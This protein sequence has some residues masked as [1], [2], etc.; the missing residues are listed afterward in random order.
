M[1]NVIALQYTIPRLKKDRGRIHP[2]TGDSVPVINVGGLLK[3][4]VLQRIL[5]MESVIVFPSEQY[6]GGALVHIPASV[7]RIERPHPHQAGNLH[8]L[9]FGVGETVLEQI[10]ELLHCWGE[11]AN[12]YLWRGGQWY[13]F[14][15]KRNRDFHPCY[16]ICPPALEVARGLQ[17][18]AG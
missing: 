5:G 16:G 17:S 15:D 8:Y 18:G 13:S 10:C 11:A 3:I 1:D 7:A 9:L 6:G 14:P 12:L 4:V 2:V